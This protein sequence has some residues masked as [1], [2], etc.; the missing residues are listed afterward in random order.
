MDF[1]YRHSMNGL[2]TTRC[3]VSYYMTFGC[4]LPSLYVYACIGVWACMRDWDAKEQM[5]C[6]ARN[7]ELACFWFEEKKREFEFKV[8]LQ[9]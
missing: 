1:L 8:C 2:F 7:K 3:S 4:T 5:A 6:G 9:T